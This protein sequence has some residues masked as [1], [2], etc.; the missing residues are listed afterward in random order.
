MNPDVL[1]FILQVVAIAFGGGTVQL[2]IAFLRKKSEIRQLDS[3]SDLNISNA[4]ATLITRLQE[5]GATYRE[6]VKG[7]QDEIARLKERRDQEQYEF[8]QRLQ[9]AHA[10]NARLATRVAQIQ[11]DLDIA[12]RQILDLR[13]MGP[14]L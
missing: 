9:D 6:I 13:R 7:L 3:S 12:Q 5:D 2:F 14:T 8:A 10:E 11:T 4:S 1:K